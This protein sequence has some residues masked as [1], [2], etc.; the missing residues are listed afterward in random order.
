M[1]NGKIERFTINDPL[2]S[3][4]F[5]EEVLTICTGETTNI[6]VQLTGTPPWTLT[7]TVDNQNPQTIN[8]ITSSPYLINSSIAGTYRL[9]ALSDAQNNSS[10]FTGSTTIIEKPVPTATVVSNNTDFCAGQPAQAQVQFSGQGPWELTYTINGTNSTTITGITTNP[11]LF[12]ATQTGEYTLTA[13]KGP[14]CDGI[15]IPGNNSLTIHELPSASIATT[16]YTICA[17]QSASIPV[18]L[19]GAA[20]WTF[21]YTIN[22]LNPVSITTNNANYQILTS[23]AGDYHVTQVNDAYCDGI[24]ITGNANVAVSYKPQPSFGYTANNTLISFS[25]NSQNATWYFW[26]FGDSKTS[27]AQNPVH[28]YKFPGVYSVTL[29]ASNPNCGSVKILRTIVVTN[30]NDPRPIPSK[31]ELVADNAQM[32]LEMLMDV[33]PNPTS[34]KFTLELSNIRQA[35]FLV[36]ITDVTGRIV[37]SEKLTKAETIDNEGFYT[38]SLDLSNYSEGVYSVQVITDQAAITSKLV[39]SK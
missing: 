6:P 20:P 35:N 1:N 7:Y 2:P 34:G 5:N 11:Y 21:T 3:A 32:L 10:C 25:N 26:S 23:V 33:Y 31:D 16:T 8:G 37:Y 38:T 4:K 29:I 39:L 30:N 27:N 14:D 36:E 18:S 9:T 22:G 24:S 13:V 28:K 15:L 12:E 19:T 17:G